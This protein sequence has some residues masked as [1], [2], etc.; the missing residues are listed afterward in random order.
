MIQQASD[1][2]EVRDS[3]IEYRHT[4][5]NTCAFRRRFIIFCFSKE[6]GIFY[7]IPSRDSWQTKEDGAAAPRYRI[8]KTFLACLASLEVFR[9]ARVNCLLFASNI[10]TW[11]CR[12][13]EQT[14]SSRNQSITRLLFCQVYK[15]SYAAREGAPA[16][17]SPSLLSCWSTYR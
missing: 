12:I 9:V 1:A 14:H 16:C 13:S 3:E 10:P 8:D 11:M 2:A 6:F 15:C 4:H 7:P 17:S 5:T